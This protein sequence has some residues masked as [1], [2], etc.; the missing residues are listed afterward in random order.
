MA[1]I[2]ACSVQARPNVRRESTTPVLDPGR[3]RTKTG[4]LGRMPAMIAP[5]V[6]AIRQVSAP[7]ARPI[8]QSLKC[9]DAADDGRGDPAQ[10]SLPSRVSRSPR[11]DGVRGR[12]SSARSAVELRTRLGV[13]RFLF[14]DVREVS[15]GGQLDGSPLAPSSSFAKLRPETRERRGCFLVSLSIRAASGSA[16]AGRAMYFRQCRAWGCSPGYPP[17]TTA[18]ANSFCAARVGRG[19]AISNSAPDCTRGTK[20]SEHWNEIPSR[21]MPASSRR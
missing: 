6:A 20:R 3:R 14:P 4:Q 2:S 11:W 12:R 13:H 1:F 19:L 16:I 21:G 15:S 17:R 5:G 7:I 9:L 8:G 18:W 10:P